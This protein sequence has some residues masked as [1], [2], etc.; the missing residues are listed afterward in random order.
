MSFLKRMTIATIL[1]G[2][3]V[4]GGA[5]AAEGGG[6]SGWTSPVAPGLRFQLECASIR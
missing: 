6:L 5:Y 3:V 4:S 2:L 1:A